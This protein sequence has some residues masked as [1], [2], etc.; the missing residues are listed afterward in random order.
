MMLLL[1]IVL[2]GDNAV[3]IAI[4][5]KNLENNIKKKAIIIGVTLAVL[6]RLVLAIFINYIICIPFVHLIGGILL[7]FIAIKLLN[8]SDNHNDKKSDISLSSA[9]KTIVISDLIMSIDN[10]LAI[11]AVANGDIVMII[12]G[13]LMSIPFLVFGSNLLSNIMNKYPIIVYLGSLLITLTGCKMMLDD[14]IAS[15]YILSFFNEYLF[16][17]LF[18][19]ITIFFS[20]IKRRW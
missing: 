9:I 17:F 4:A 14:S 6:I 20:K 16:I 5:T 11:I 1:N 2:S 7:I 10:V 12:L 19:I 15:V 13:L 8:G 3:V 18:F